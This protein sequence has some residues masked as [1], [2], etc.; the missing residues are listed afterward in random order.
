MK[1]IGALAGLFVAGIVSS[2]AAETPPPEPIPTTCVGEQAIKGTNTCLPPGTFVKKLCTVPYPDMALTM[3]AKGTPW[4]RVWLAGDV[5][6]W[7]ASGGFTSRTQ[8]AF[9]EEVIVLSR[10]SAP[11]A[12]GVVMSGNT[13]FDVLRWDG[14]CVS[15]LEGELTLRR[16]P[17]PKPAAKMPWTRLEEATKRALLTTP[18]V[19]ST[20]DALEKACA[21]DKVACDRAEKDFGAAIAQSVRAGTPLP[22]PTRRP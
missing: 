6:A 12:G 17:Q 7:N 1:R 3:F 22:V 8:L 21:S 2:A 13:S 14:S 4:T 5:E 20:R 16:P 11:S 10:H 15:V 9:D 18:K 19:K